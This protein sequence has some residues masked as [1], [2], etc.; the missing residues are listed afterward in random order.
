MNNNKN[1]NNE[2][3]RKKKH[4]RDDGQL[5]KNIKISTRNTQ[6]QQTAA[7]RDSVEREIQEK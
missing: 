7:T 1:N 3:K 2:K 6:A 4:E 5:N